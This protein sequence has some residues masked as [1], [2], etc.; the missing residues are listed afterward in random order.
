MCSLEPEKNIEISNFARS[1]T[2]MLLI[3]HSKMDKTLLPRPVIQHPV[4][5]SALFRQAEMFKYTQVW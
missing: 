5:P 1:N 2:Y 3:I 4:E